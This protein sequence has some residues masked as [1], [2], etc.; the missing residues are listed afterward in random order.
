MMPCSYSFP[1]PNAEYVWRS[2]PLQASAAADAG[3]AGSFTWAALV[4]AIGIVLTAVLAFVHR[5]FD[6][7]AKLLE[8]DG[9]VVV[10]LSAEVNRLAKKT[11]TED[12]LG[13]IKELLSLLKQAERRFPRIPFGTIVATVEVYEKA[14]IS[15]ECAKAL[16]RVL[17]NRKFVDEALKL[18]R[19]QG[20]RLAAVRA[21][22]ETV[23][24]I[25]DRKL[26]R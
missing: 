14:V 15:E 21:A 20:V 18:S 2:S 12:D 4:T 5:W 3:F 22:I 17:A 23:Q 26:R 7:R 11:A 9:A 24:R 6:K 25:I 19:E 13:E 16:K 1:W 8:Q 10:R